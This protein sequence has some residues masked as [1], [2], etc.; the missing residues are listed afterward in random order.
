MNE[1]SFEDCDKL[2]K[3]FANGTLIEGLRSRFVDLPEFPETSKRPRAK[4]LM[5]G[6]VVASVEG[7]CRIIQYGSVIVGGWVPD[8]VTHSGLI[9]TQIDVARS[10]KR[11]LISKKES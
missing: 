9:N 6:S 10:I 3:R 11:Y 8:S 7:G 1:H 5:G 2:R 4:I